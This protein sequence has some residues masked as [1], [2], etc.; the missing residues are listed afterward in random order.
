MF[1]RS[2]VIA[3]RE[4]RESL[5]LKLIFL[6]FA[7]MGV[8]ALM[9]W[10]TNTQAMEAAMNWPTTSGVV[11]ESNIRW[12]PPETGNDYGAFSP[13]LHYSYNVSGT[14]F[15]GDRIVFGIF[16]F[17]YQSN[18]QDFINNYP[19]GKS[20]IVHYDPNN[21]Q[22]SILFPEVNQ[23]TAPALIVGCAFIAI[24][25]IGEIL[26]FRFKDKLDRKEQGPSTP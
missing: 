6:V 7:V 18:A 13:I 4:V 12:D 8:I 1:R 9:I 14:Q 23:E 3:G 2:D 11:T 24:G 5:R 20:V 25:M 21:P 17:R 15:E 26:A 22:S 19:I 16:A 10:L